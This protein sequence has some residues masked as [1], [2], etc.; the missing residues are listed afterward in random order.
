MK[1]GIIVYSHT[2]NTKSVAETL[3]QKLQAGGHTAELVQVTVEGNG[4]PGSTPVELADRPSLDGYEGLVFGSPVHGFSL[5]QAMQRYLRE[6][7][8]LSG[9]PIG[10]LVTEYFPYAW[11]GGN[12]AARQM[13]SI[14]EGKGGV[15]RDSVVVNWKNAR[16]ETQIAEGTDRLAALF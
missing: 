9:R 5:S 16:R 7:E 12:R 4:R 10:L 3:Q 15:V 8:D 1:I 13:R 2:G 14:I 6:Q 11:M